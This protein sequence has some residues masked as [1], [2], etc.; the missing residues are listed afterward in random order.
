MR[1]T[2]V[3]LRNFRSF[4]SE[5]NEQ[6]VEIDLTGGVNYLVGSNNVGKS[7]LLRA[8][9]LA[10]V[11]RARF[12]PAID[13]PE[14]RSSRTSITL[15]LHAGE[16]RS[17][18]VVRLLKIVDAI[19]SRHPDATA[20]TLASKGIIRFRVGFDHDGRRLEWFLP[21]PA[22][23][24]AQ[25]AVLPS[26]ESAPGDFDAFHNLVR[27]VD[28]RS[29]ED[30]DSLLQRG[31][32]EIL[33][34]AMGAEHT[35]AMRAAEDARSAYV[36]ALGQVLRPVAAHVQ[37]QISRYVRGI[38]E[39]DLEPNVPPV[40][41]AVAAAR[42]FLKDAVR[43]PLDQK[44]TGVRGAMLVLLL[45][46]IA[47]SAKGVVVFGIEEPEAFLHPEAHR[48]LGA[49]L[50]RFRAR[51]D[52]TL[53]VTTHSPFLF[54]SGA[55]GDRTAVFMVEKDAHGRSSVRR[56]EATAARTGLFGSVDVP[57]LLEAIEKVPEGAKLLL[58]V[59]GVTD[60]AY[61]LQASAKLGIPL[62][63]VHILPRGG[64]AGAV[65]EAV[66]LGMR[67]APGRAVAALFDSDGNGN[68]SYDLLAE[69]FHWKERAGARLFALTCRQWIKDTNVPV[70]SED[71]F[72]HATLER[73]L[74]EPGHG[75]FMTEKVKR[76][77][78]LGGWHIGLTGAG[79]LALVT[80]LEQ[81]GTVEM[82]EPWRTVLEH[83]RKL[84]AGAK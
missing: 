62:D 3:T 47:D 2:K 83:L 19:Q 79:K 25:A 53:L 37:N 24:R 44:G 54:R 29:G 77:G 74:G 17:A 6:S 22:I 4:W 71:F 82:F 75:D 41:D 5:G 42:V 18:A 11:P 31:F 49:G 34:S 58:V 27:F 61:L 73:F 72:G 38:E 78:K 7:N 69:T 21:D 59:E 9:H 84:V 80:W 66:T 56:A 13:R 52:V 26:S 39:V 36:D 76:P 28:I 23:E 65:L 33:T 43:T 48:E 35:K 30:L 50:E 14:G 63:D 55:E 8:V 40:A 57:A 15:E 68:E 45:S 20:P 60:R 1:L 67:H 51:D 64:A 70:E 81:N 46:F 16:H 10:L 32:K 12:N